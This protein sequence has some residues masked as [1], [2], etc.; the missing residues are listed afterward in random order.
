M[1]AFRI[2]TPTFNSGWMLEETVRSVVRCLGPEDRY[3]IVDGGSTDGSVEALRQWAPRNV[4]F[5]RDSGG[6]MYDAITTGFSDC[7]E[8]L[9]AWINAS[10]VYLDGALDW[11]RAE[12]VRTQADLVHFDDLYIDNHGSVICRSRG[13]VR[14]IRGAMR[15]GWTP[16]QDGCFWTSAL[17]RATGGITARWKLAGDFDFFLRA[18]QHGTTA[19]GRGVVSAFRRHEGQLSRSKSNAYADERRMILRADGGNGFRHGFRCSPSNLARRLSLAISARTG[20]MRTTTPF[21][22][23]DVRTLHACL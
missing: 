5:R 16:L 15:V 22:N 9:M 7:E 13:T 14:N 6:G 1:P 11:V 2:V 3:I 12:F 23:A 10:D 17:Y 18:F 4:E 21:A 20:R 8:P 19:H